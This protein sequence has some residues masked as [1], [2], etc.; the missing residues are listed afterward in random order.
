MK[1]TTHFHNGNTR[2]NFDNNSGDS[3]KL[4]D[5][6]LSL[7]DAI[8]VS[9]TS[10]INQKAI[11]LS[12]TELIGCQISVNG[13]FNGN[14][15]KTTLDQKESNQGEFNNNGLDDD[16]KTNS[17]GLSR[18]D[19]GLSASKTAS[20]NE[21]YIDEETISLH[22]DNPFVTHFGEF[23]SLSQELP[24]VNC[25][26]DR[27]SYNDVCVYSMSQSASI[28]N[29]SNVIKSQQMK[30]YVASGNNEKENGSSDYGRIN[31]ID[32]NILH[33]RPNRPHSI[34][35]AL[36]AA[37][38]SPSSG[39]SLA[40]LSVLNQNKGELTSLITAGAAP[41]TAATT[42]LTY[43]NS[44]GTPN[45][46]IPVSNN[47]AMKS[48]MNT[49][50]NVRNCNQNAQKVFNQP[51][52]NEYAQQAL[53][54]VSYGHFI[55]SPSRL[56]TN[57]QQASQDFS[58][59]SPLLATVTSINNTSNN[60]PQSG[61]NRQ[62]PPIVQRRSNSTPRVQSA[63]LLGISADNTNKSTP[64][65]VNNN[66]IPVRP[67]SL[68]RASFNDLAAMS[69]SRPPP[70]PP[71]RRF[72]QQIQQIQLPSSVQYPPTS[73]S[74]QQRSVSSTL[75]G[76]IR[77][78]ATFHGQLNRHTTNTSH[79]NSSLSG[80]KNVC[81]SNTLTRKA[82]RPVSFAYGTL[83]EQNYLENQLR[84]Y[85][86]QLRSITESVRKYS[87]QA[88]ILSEMKRTQQMEKNRQL[89]L[90]SP[91]ETTA[92]F[93]TKADDMVISSKNLRLF[94]DS[95]RHKMNE[96]EHVEPSPPAPISSSSSSI[97]QTQ[98]TPL[99][100]TSENGGI[101]TKTVTE[102]K[103]PSDQLRQFLDA[104]RSNQLP[105][106]DQSDL[107]SAA[108]R[109]SK[110]KEKMEHS[111]SKSTPNFSQYQI[112]TNVN[113]SFSKLSD[114]LRIMNEDL[115][116]LAV[117]TPQ[118]NVLIQKAM[119]S[120]T[121]KKTERMD[122][123]QILDKFCQMTNNTHSMETIEYLRKCSDVLKHSTNQ[124]KINN[125]SFSDSADS[126]SCST[127]PGSI[128]E[129]VQNLLQ[130][131]RNGVQI[132]DDRMKLFIDILDTQSKFSQVNIKIH[133]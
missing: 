31:D 97:N 103:T 53:K 9:G 105:E 15:N 100:K 25:N 85:S 23:S 114:N 14:N 132:M 121:S 22:L 46:N 84:M 71:S 73:S 112:S 87:E 70:I 1:S 38:F 94:L 49:L 67:R 39:H 92:L 55:N 64:S 90:S 24:L 21:L 30:N 62:P 54:H 29:L 16:E 130:Q 109:F 7:N 126:S 129:A 124:G 91:Q 106:E 40:R 122:F 98:K 10:I 128:R 133:S 26:N 88:K 41:R 19:G 43:S 120:I 13:F 110:F 115:E 32:N 61:Q 42:T 47:S 35:G 57:R 50:N 86:E 6:I 36:S 8:T 2:D 18:R 33:N 51:Q 69:H 74:F 48:S 65:T 96:I 117:A 56:T 102:A 104:I 59:Y 11:N 63:V 131:P 123:N 111:R 58:L 77:Q 72:S 4:N 37:S 89:E 28:L 44:Y 80:N 78:S 93:I 119:P 83:P 82:D 79:S 60:N 108:D 52:N 34:A 95:V 3:V 127:T 99:P 118:K 68:D 125:N 27:P 5:K 76:G 20:S 81:Q 66:G 17:F 45:N 101:S 116:A 75:A 107:S 12:Q 113:N